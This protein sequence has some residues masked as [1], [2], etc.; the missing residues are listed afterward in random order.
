MALAIHMA[1][2]P[3][4]DYC[5]KQPEVRLKRAPLQSSVWAMSG[6]TSKM[7]SV[8]GAS[9]QP[10]DADCVRLNTTCMLFRAPENVPLR[11]ARQ[12]LV[13][14]E[15]VS[16]SAERGTPTRASTPSEDNIN[17]VR[18][19]T[20]CVLFRSMESCDEMRFRIERQAM[21]SSS[22][23]LSSLCSMTKNLQLLCASDTTC[24]LFRVSQDKKSKLPSRVRRQALQSCAWNRSNCNAPLLGNQD[25]PVRRDTTCVLFR[26]GLE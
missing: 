8:F 24:V 6:V 18:R 14:S 5:G 7:A 16:A 20:T 2:G 12:P 9:A 15:W 19:D 3:N 22:W 4:S 1:Q 10:R 25:E 13:S 17:I 26:I 21:L 11:V 23:L